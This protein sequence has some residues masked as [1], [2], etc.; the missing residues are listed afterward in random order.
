[1]SKPLSN[2]YHKLYH[3]NKMTLGF[4]PP[5]EPMT[6]Q[7]PKMDNTLDIAKKL[8]AY[9]FGAIWLRDVMMHDLS[10]NDH[11]QLFDLW[12]YLGYLAANTKDIVLGTS[13]I[14]LP[15]R[16]PVRTAHIASSIEQLY[17][18]RLIM[19][20]ASGDRKKDF[21]ALGVDRETRGEQFIQ[22]YETLEHLL[23]QE[24]PA[25][26]NEIAYID[27]NEVQMMPQTNKRIPIFP[28]GFAQN[29]IDW[30][31]QHGDGWIQ[32][33]RSPH[34]Q[35]QLIYDYRDLVS[36]HNKEQFK[37]F[38]QTLYIDL[39]ENPN[40]VP[41]AIPLGFR[42]GRNHLKELLYQY[43]DIGVNHLAFVPYFARRPVEDIVD[44]LG[45]EI[46]PL[47]PTHNEIN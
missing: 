25:I 19:G 32:Y 36:Q 5:F 3:P 8:E 29:S 34:E 20:V 4:L 24:T 42:L 2:A 40:H 35:E 12:T 31:A 22:S 28:T 6:T 17:P 45:E 1:M 7:L 37:P 11:G 41:E 26:N 38:T 21:L 16:H 30:L 39:T 13:S 44:E 18:E 33:P 10:S 15:L 43:Q 46:V 9:G 23:S 14:V 47:F 27:G